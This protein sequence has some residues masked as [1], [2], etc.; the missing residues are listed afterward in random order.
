MPIFVSPDSADV[1]AHPDLFQLDRSGRPR[2]VAGVPPDQFSKTGQRWGNPLYDWRRMKKDGFAW[3][4]RRL[5]GRWTQ[6]TSCGSTTSAGSSRTGASPPAT[7]TAQSGRWV[8]APGRELF[9]ALRSKIGD[10][11]VIAEDLGVITPA[12][13]RLRDRFALPGMRVLQFAF[14][15]RRQP[16]PAAQLRPPLHR[17]HRHPRQRHDRRLVPQAHQG[18][19]GT[20]CTATPPTP[21]RARRGR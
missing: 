12:V 9:E 20:A 15:G 13:E 19:R 14:D 8:R 5:R 4:S 2:A 3:W 21:P 7:P 1:W 6:P 17:L 10:L 11:P 18:R 16:A